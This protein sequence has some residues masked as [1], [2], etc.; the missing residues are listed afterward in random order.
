MSI[1]FD[2]NKRRAVMPKMVRRKTS[3]GTIILYDIDDRID[4]GKYKGEEL[5][6]IYTFEPSYIEWLIKNAKR[7][8]IDIDQFQKYHCI[9]MPDELI[10]YHNSVNVDNQILTVRQ[11]IER[12]FKL[13]DDY[14]HPPE[15]IKPFKFSPVC[16]DIINKRRV[17]FDE[18]KPI[19]KQK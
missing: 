16:I 12:Y 9:G 4:F 6:F 2:D 13:M 7:F 17:L 3:D 14:Y 19:T 8:L 11:Y 5:K 1:F 15:T 10:G 18:G